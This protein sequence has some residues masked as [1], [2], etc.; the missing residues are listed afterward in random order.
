MEVTIIVTMRASSRHGNL[1]TE[2]LPQAAKDAISDVL[3]TK[4]CG[5]GGFIKGD[6]FIEDFKVSLVDTE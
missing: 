1:K 3:N 2:D 4:E 6:C 5:Y